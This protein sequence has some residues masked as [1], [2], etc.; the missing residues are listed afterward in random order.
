MIYKNRF[1][2]PTITQGQ[3]NFL[4]TIRVLWRDLAT[5]TRAYL[6]NRYAGLAITEDV[7]NR[8]YEIPQEFGNILQ[9]IF[10][11]D[12]AQ[13]FVQYVS[14]QI[15]QIRSLIE[16]VIEGDVN[17][18]NLLTQQMYQLADER[19]RFMTSINPFW[20]LTETRNLIYTYL[21]LTID[22]ITTLLTG[23]YKRNIDIFD[24]LLHHTDNMGDYFSQG[25]L[26]YITY[27]QHYT[28]TE[29]QQSNIQQ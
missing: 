10:G 2:E 8:L 17:S 24:R 7:F 16:A 27:S 6:V 13:R 25:L 1:I 5:W 29:Q 28:P 20:D 15:V 23:D 9:F 19:A 26:N 22:Q 11:Y 4:F 21:Q 3:M 18:V 12:N 14:Q